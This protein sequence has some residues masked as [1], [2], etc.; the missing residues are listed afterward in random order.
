MIHCIH[1]HLFMDVSL[2]GIKSIS[3]FGHL[4]GV[5]LITS[6][7]ISQV[8]FTAA[9]I[10]EVSCADTDTAVSVFGSEELLLLQAA[11]IVAVK[12]KDIKIACFNCFRFMV[13]GY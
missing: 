7:C 10:F 12:N 3:H 1:I 2:N 4:P 6:G 8:Y 11:K 9:I 13:S 5:S